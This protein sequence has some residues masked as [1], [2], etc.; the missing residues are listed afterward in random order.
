MNVVRTLPSY[1]LGR[2]AILGDAVS[3][4]SEGLGLPT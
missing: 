1:D 3:K 2:V 4:P